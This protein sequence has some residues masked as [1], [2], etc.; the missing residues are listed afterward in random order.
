MTFRGGTE[1][2]SPEGGLKRKT[3]CQK[4]TKN[5]KFQEILKV[6]AKLAQE[7]TTPA[8]EGN[9][10]ERRIKFQAQ[11]LQIFGPTF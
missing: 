3:Y 6:E 5:W 2:I 7:R 1:S 9:R 8:K 4:K 11:T 10:A